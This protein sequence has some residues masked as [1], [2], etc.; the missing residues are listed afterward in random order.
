[1]AEIIRVDFGQ[2]KL[3]GKEIVGAPTSKPKEIKQ[4]KSK[5]TNMERKLHE[6]NAL[7]NAIRT[8][9]KLPSSLST[10]TIQLETIKNYSKDELRKWLIE[11]T[12]IDWK[13]KPSFFKTIVEEYSRKGIELFVPGEK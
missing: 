8:I 6:M 10:E 9:Q 12:E 4:E 5:L 11:T 7:S 13:K 1:M 2:R 3:S